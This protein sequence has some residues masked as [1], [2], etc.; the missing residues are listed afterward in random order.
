MAESVRDLVQRFC[1]DMNASM[2]LGKVF[3]DTSE[4]M[5]IESGD[6]IAVGGRHYLVLR[7]EA[8][9]RFGVE[10]PKFWVKRCR[11]LETGERKILKL[12]FYENFTLRIGELEIRC[13]RSPEK[14]ARILNLVKGDWRFMQ[15]ETQF[16]EKRNAVRVL[17][18]VRGK[19]LDLKVE[20]IK[21]D[22]E[23]YFFEHFP[24]LLEKFIGSAEAIGF[25][26]AHW[27]K[28]GDI[29][30]DH[31]LVEY[32][33]GNF[34]WIDFDYAFESLENPFGLDLFGL[35]NIL[36]VLIG[37]GEHNIHSLGQEGYPDQ[38]LSS[39]TPDDFSLMWA[40]R[41]FNLRKLYPYIPVE[42]NRV[43]MHFSAGTYVTYDN[44]PEML[45]ELRPCLKLI[46]P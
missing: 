29:R 14:E 2:P 26:H 45:E 31:I 16:D 46:R 21:A 32:E 9:R 5:R 6:V 41:L 23:T 35:G 13:H 27:E 22:H 36:S 33:T 18:V 10:D 17:D 40:H 44:V 42:L 12:V 28:H 7:D 19:R 3:T 38:V 8:E 37:K 43:L 24:A 1:P 30:R 25:L 4:F 34:R 20:D 39:L 11:E 15:G